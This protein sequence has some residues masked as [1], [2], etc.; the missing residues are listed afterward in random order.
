MLHDKYPGLTFEVH[1]AAM[2]AINSHAIREI[3]ADCA[4]HDPDLFILYMG[5]NEVV[6]PFGPGT[7]L[8]PCRRV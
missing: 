1:T 6:G 2:V 3:A 5:N 7:C 8:P 4:E